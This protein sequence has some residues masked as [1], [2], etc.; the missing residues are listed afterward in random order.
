MFYWDGSRFAEEGPTRPL[1]RILTQIAI[2][3]QLHPTA[4]WEAE[5]A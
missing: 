4:E 2:S 1:N 5:R 3:D